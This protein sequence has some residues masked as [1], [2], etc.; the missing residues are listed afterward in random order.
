[1][2]SLKKFIPFSSSSATKPDSE[3]ALKARIKMLESQVK[4]VKDQRQEEHNKFEKN[5]AEIEK[6]HEHEL[7][8]VQNKAIKSGKLRIIDELTEDMVRL[9]FEAERYDNLA[10]SLNWGSIQAYYSVM[11][12]KSKCI[13][14]KQTNAQ[15]PDP[16]CAVCG[17]KFT[18][19]G[20][21]TPRLLECGNTVCEDCLVARWEHSHS[22]PQCNGPSGVDNPADLKKNYVLVGMLR[23]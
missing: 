17:Q 23:E 21:R 8:K 10:F 6:K 9:S 4:K 20:P 2:S 19:D 3:K 7:V 5:M 11:T 14:L 15:I 22:C 12:A 18:E 1:M 13:S 16:T